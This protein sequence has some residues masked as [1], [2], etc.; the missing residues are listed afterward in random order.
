LSG[1]TYETDSR[2]R[3]LDLIRGAIATLYA[4]GM[5]WAG[6]MKFLL[7]SAIVYAPGS[8]LFFLARREQGKPL[9]I[10]GEWLLFIVLVIAAFGGVYGLVAGTVTI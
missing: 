1:K 5:I 2:D 8:L 6:G 4:F 3:T 9:F 10:L 7:L